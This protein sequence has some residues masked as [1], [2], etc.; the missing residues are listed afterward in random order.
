M[1]T[2]DLLRADVGRSRAAP[3]FVDPADQELL[4]VA[5]ELVDE[6]RAHE[7]KS[8]GE[9]R[10]ALEG[11]ARAGDRVRLERGLAK[12]LQDRSTFERSSAVDPEAA[13]ALVF[14]RA[15]EAR[16]RGVFSRESV[17]AAAAPELGVAS[18]REVEVAL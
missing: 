4:A 7:G 6:F 16:S 12:L 8:R 3:R 14:A 18:A 11:R 13:R 10:V 2:G 15:S 1:L 17:L 9:L 5:S